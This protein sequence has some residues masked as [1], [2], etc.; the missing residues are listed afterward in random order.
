M[1]HVESGI[2]R[3]KRKRNAAAEDERTPNPKQRQRRQNQTYCAMFQ[4]PF[5]AQILFYPSRVSVP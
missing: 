1:T 2:I 5:K 3:E 4:K